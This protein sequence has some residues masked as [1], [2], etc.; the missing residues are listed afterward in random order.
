[1]NKNN[2]MDNSLQRISS[3]ENRKRGNSVLWENEPNNLGN[4]TKV[5]KKE[6]IG[7]TNDNRNPDLNSVNN[8][9]RTFS[10]IKFPEY[11][12]PECVFS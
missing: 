10:R 3:E 4:S 11:R 7:T 8:G 5:S 1:M 9:Y 6:T 2:N 12:P